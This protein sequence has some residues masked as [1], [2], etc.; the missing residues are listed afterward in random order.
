MATLVLRPNSDSSC[1]WDGAYYDASHYANVD[2]S[3]ADGTST[4]NLVSYSAG[5]RTDIFNFTNH[6]SEVGTINSVTLYAVALGAY[7]DDFYLIVNG[8]QGSKINVTSDWA[9]YSYN[10]GGSWTWSGIDSITGGVRGVVDNNA[11]ADIRC[12]QIYIVVDYTPVVAPTVSTSSPVVDI[13][14]AYANVAGNI[15]NTGGGSCTQRGI[16]YNT[17]GSPTTGDSKVY[18]SGSYS[19]GAFS[20]T[21]TGLSVSTTYH[22]KAYAINSAGTSYGSEVDFTTGATVH[23]SKLFTFKG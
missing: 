8:S 17:T 10:P 23:S 19:T 18:D 4:F 20:K 21:L 14:G 5:D 12:T 7:G 2:D 6:T 13:G 22:C 11:V 3:V 1:T 15:T 9:T 16:C